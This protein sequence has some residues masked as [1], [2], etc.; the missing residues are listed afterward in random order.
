[1]VNEYKDKDNKCEM[2][3]DRCATCINT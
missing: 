2:C 1:L 3:N